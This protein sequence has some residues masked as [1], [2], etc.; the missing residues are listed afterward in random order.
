ME[1]DKI[2]VRVVRGNA[3]ADGHVGRELRLLPHAAERPGFERVIK[4]LNDLLLRRHF[5]DGQLQD[6]IVDHLLRP[7]PVSNRRLSGRDEVIRN[8]A[9]I[10]RIVSDHT[11]LARIRAG[12]GAR[13][14]LRGQH[15]E[16]RFE[17]VIDCRPD[18]FFLFSCERGLVGSLL[19]RFRPVF[20]ERHRSKPVF[21]GSGDVREDCN[22]SFLSERQANRSNLSVAVDADLERL[23]G[24]GGKRRT[25]ASFREAKHNGVEVDACHLAGI[26][27]PHAPI[28]DAEDN[29]LPGHPRLEHA[30]ACVIVHVSRFHLRNLNLTVHLL[31]QHQNRVQTR[32]LV[33][34]LR[35]DNGSEP[36]RT[37]VAVHDRIWRCFAQNRRMYLVV[38]KVHE[39]IHPIAVLVLNHQL[40]IQNTVFPALSGEIGLIVPVRRFCVVQLMF[41][42]ARANH[43]RRVLRRKV[44]ICQ[45]IEGTINL[46]HR[47][48]KI[49]CGRCMV[50]GT[51]RKRAGGQQQAH[52]DDKYQGDSC[53][54]W[55][56][57]NQT[58]PRA[59]RLFAGDHR[60]R[61]ERRLHGCAFDGDLVEKRPSVGNA[62]AVL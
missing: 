32:I 19:R 31:R 23:S 44:F 49:G 6:F 61:A 10:V 43:T 55:L 7:R 28:G 42:G 13:L 29:G 12:K 25:D 54:L 17:L 33:R 5:P 39:R 57:R 36:A 21:P 27:F 37:K 18:G 11:V 8:C 40:S 14:V 34:P 51:V 3:N 30:V 62:R 53:H 24:C 22:I 26:W 4:M 35:R 20:A 50:C 15:P 9:V 52:A 60:C 1:H 56:F 38:W 47:R 2:F 46:N 16:R 45:L 59:K 48:K 41:D 58:D